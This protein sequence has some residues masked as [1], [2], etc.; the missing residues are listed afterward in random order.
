MILCYI[1]EQMADFEIS[2]L[3]HRLKNTDKR[4]IVAISE[5]TEAI[6][7]QS[8]LRY[9]PD[10]KISD[11]TSLDDIEAL[12]LPGGPINNS[13]NDICKLASDLTAAG[14]LVAAICF[15]PQFLGRAGILDKYRYTTSCP[16]EKIA[17]L[18]CEDP[19]NREN[20]VQARVVEDRNLITAQGY[21]FVD[22]AGAVC[23]Y[24]H[25]FQDEHQEYEQ[26]GRIKEL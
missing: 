5:H 7:A 14:R 11:I 17:Q 9:L 3:L 22:F 20:F 15:A 1:Y 2:L 18:G 6:T 24:L 4:E 8:G 26:I 23:R 16:A 10:K 13:Q 21:A 12:I 25:I 19:F